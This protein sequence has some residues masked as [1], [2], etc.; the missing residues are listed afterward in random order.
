[1]SPE[2]C[3]GTSF[4]WCCQ[5]KVRNKIPAPVPSLT[6]SV[7]R[8]AAVSAED[9]RPTVAAGRFPVC[10]MSHPDWTCGPALAPEGTLALGMHVLPEILPQSFCPQHLRWEPSVRESECPPVFV[11]IPRSCWRER[12]DEMRNLVVAAQLGVFV[13]P[14]TMMTTTREN[15]SFVVIL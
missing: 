5:R 6:V 9:A 8:P 15:S 13:K 3:S 2:L 7:L 14:W 4:L 1:M 10:V 12:A 11:C